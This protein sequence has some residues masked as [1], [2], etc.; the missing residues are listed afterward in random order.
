MLVAL[1][2]AGIWTFHRKAFRRFRPTR[3]RR[4]VPGPAARSC[5]GAAPVRRRSR[6]G[7][8]SLAGGA[9]EA[10]LLLLPGRRGRDA[11]ALRPQS[12]SWRSSSRSCSRCLTRG[13]ARQLAVFTVFG[14]LGTSGGRDPDRLARE[15]PRRHSSGAAS[16]DGLVNAGGRAR[17]RS[18]RRKGRGV[19]HAD[20]RAS[21][22]SASI[23]R[24][25]D[26]G[27]RADPAD[28]RPAS[29]TRSDI[30]LLELANLNHPALKELI[31]QAP[32]TY[33]HSIIM[34]SLVEAA[35]EAIG[36]QPAARAGAA[37][38]TTTSERAGTR[39][40]SARTRRA[41]TATTSSRRR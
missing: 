22:F 20:R 23:A 15:G 11:G 21:P 38:T 17:L 9:D 32:G 24:R 41:R 14:L 5:S 31:V 28:S 1:L 34:G 3:Q 10:L 19:R 29:A 2:L 18:G 16:V 7:A 35:A 25:P 27:D 30:K 6:S 26:A 40:T 39:S 12:R 8:R 4:A 36:A 33:H 37:P 13:D